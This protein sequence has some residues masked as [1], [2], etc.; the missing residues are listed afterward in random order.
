MRL[1]E[2]IIKNKEKILWAFCNIYGNDLYNKIANRFDQIEFLFPNLQPEDYNKCLDEIC[3]HPN[4]VES[5]PQIEV[6]RKIKDVN[7]CGFFI[8][9]LRKGENNDFTLHYFI[10]INSNSLDYSYENLDVVLFHELKHDVIK[11]K[12]ETYAFLNL[13]NLKSGEYRMLSI[14]EVKK[15]YSLK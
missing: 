6:I 8:P 1:Q 2:Y 5:I 13:G 3:Y 4:N 10:I 12:R 11:L 14:K 7:E 9:L 15:L